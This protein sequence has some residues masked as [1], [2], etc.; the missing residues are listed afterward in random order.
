[1]CL[2]TY[3]YRVWS[4]ASAY[5]LQPRVGAGLGVGGSPPGVGCRLPLVEGAGRAE[6]LAVAQQAGEQIWLRRLNR[7]PRRSRWQRT[8]VLAAATK[9]GTGCR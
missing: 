6:A 7:V 5:Y 1:M 3:G 4:D 9:S 2:L 8:A